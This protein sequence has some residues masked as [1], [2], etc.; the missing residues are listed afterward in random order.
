VTDHHPTTS[1]VFL[2]FNEHDGGVEPTDELTGEVTDELLSTGEAARLLG[3]SRQH[4]VDLCSRGD[5]P[6]VSVGT[7]RRIRRSDVEAFLGTELTR[8]AERSLWL[9][10]AIAGRLVLDPDA[11]LATAR[12]NLARLQAVHTGGMSRRWL[13]QWERVVSRGVDDVLDALTSRVT[14]AVELRQNSPF[15]GVLT[16]QERAQVLAAFR[17]HWRRDHQAA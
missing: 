16:A 7:H 3:V 12:E 8:E 13:S 4:V 17:A 2:V 15:A 11:V 9:H 6:F 1:V 10:R 5:L 14:S